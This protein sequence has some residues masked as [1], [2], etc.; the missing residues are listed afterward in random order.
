MPSTTILDLPGDL[1]VDICKNLQTVENVL[2]L[3]NSHPILNAKIN[4]N[5]WR[6]PKGLLLGVKNTSQLVID[7]DWKLEITKPTL[8]KMICIVSKTRNL[9]ELVLEKG[10]PRL[11][12]ETIEKLLG[13]IQDH[14]SI[15]LMNIMAVYKKPEL[16]C[17]RDK[18]SW[19]TKKIHDHLCDLIKHN[20]KTLLFF[21]LGVDNSDDYVTVEKSHHDQLQISYNYDSTWNSRHIIFY[22]L[23]SSFSFGTTNK[24]LIINLRTVPS[25]AH[26]LVDHCVLACR[27]NIL[28]HINVKFSL[29]EEKTD[30]EIPS[31]EHFYNIKHLKTLVWSFGTQIPEDKIEQIFCPVGTCPYDIFVDTPK[32]K[33]TYPGTRTNTKIESN[34]LLKCFS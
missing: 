29:K 16:F 32:L 26:I 9:H 23:L 18:T 6:C 12:D 4:S 1:F 21:G 2:E 31:F 25:M 11:K 34:Q 20:S 24:T 5:F 33:K 30:C 17:R 19:P 13:F 28:E 3:Q 10:D 27:S 14:T 22:P 8:R 7:A 15:K